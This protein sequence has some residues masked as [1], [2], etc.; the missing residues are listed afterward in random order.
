MAAK[1]AFGADAAITAF[2]EVAS[3]CRSG[4]AQFD[5]IIGLKFGSLSA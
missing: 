5:S 1:S 4:R 3:A 2:I